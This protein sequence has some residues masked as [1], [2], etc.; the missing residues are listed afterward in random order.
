MSLMVTIREK[1]YEFR[2]S[3]HTHKEKEREGGEEG[4]GER[5]G[6]EERGAHTI[7]V[8]PIELQG[9]QFSAML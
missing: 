5:E 6:R 3:S 8:W 9:L 2:M 7:S 4:R 1:K